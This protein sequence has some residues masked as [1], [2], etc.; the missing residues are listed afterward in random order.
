MQLKL[1]EILS[2]F[3]IV[4]LD[5]EAQLDTSIIST[6][7]PHGLG[8]LLGLQVHDI[9]GRQQSLDGTTKEPPANSPALRLTRTLGTDMVITI[10]PGLYFIDS[11]LTTLAKSDNSQY[12]NWDLVNELKPYGGIRIEDNVLVTESGSE[13]FTRDAFAEL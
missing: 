6:F 11:L 3:N 10:E 4:S 13:N 5:A 9:G 8:H 2:N 12:I 7:F 1:A